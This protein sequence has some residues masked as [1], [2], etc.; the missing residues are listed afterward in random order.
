MLHTTGLL[1]AGTPHGLIL[2]PPHK[3]KKK[4]YTQSFYELYHLLRNEQFCSTTDFVFSIFHAYLQSITNLFRHIK[5]LKKLMST[6]IAHKVAAVY[7]C[8]KYKQ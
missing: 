6:N 2:T 8:A 3:L 4:P 1:A 7:I 5:I